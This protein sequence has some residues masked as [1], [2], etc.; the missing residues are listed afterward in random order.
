[1]AASFLDSVSSMMSTKGG[2]NRGSPSVSGSADPL[3]AEGPGWDSDHMSR[4]PSGLS[5]MGSPL[6]QS[7]L[8]L[9]TTAVWLCLVQV[10]VS[11]N[12]PGP[13]G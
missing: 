5:P 6:R 13:D 3:C 11:A 2:S 4:P 12:D 7:L 9:G 1:M 10:A 8:V